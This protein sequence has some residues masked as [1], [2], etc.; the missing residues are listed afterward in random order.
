MQSGLSAAGYLPR[1]D[2]SV[3]L[4]KTCL[5]VHGSF[6]VIPRPS[7]LRLPEKNTA[8][9]VVYKQQTFISHCL[10]AGSPGSQRL[11]VLCCVHLPAVSSQGGGGKGALQG[12]V[13]KDTNPPS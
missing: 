1:R 3:S 13:Y 2:E 7:W 8:N 5:K 9:W 11:Q 12:L 6:L 10:E 4:T